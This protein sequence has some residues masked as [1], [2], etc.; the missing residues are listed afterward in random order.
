M[1]AIVSA[2]G[3]AQLSET[4]F[5]SITEQH[6]R[7]GVNKTAIEGMYKVY[8]LVPDKHIDNF[9]NNVLLLYSI[10]DAKS[11]TNLQNYVNSIVK[12]P[13][14][15][16]LYDSRYPH[17]IYPLLHTQVD[18]KIRY[19][20][21]PDEKPDMIGSETGLNIDT[22]T[23]GEYL[24]A[25]TPE[26]VVDSL[27]KGGN[28]RDIIDISPNATLRSVVDFK[29]NGIFTID[30]I[31]EE[32]REQFIS[33]A[34]KYING[35]TSDINYIMLFNQ[36]ALKKLEYIVHS[37]NY[38]G[39]DR[40]IY[41]NGVPVGN[42]TINKYGE[43]EMDD[44]VIIPFVN[45]ISVGSVSIKNNSN[46]I[47]RDLV[48]LGYVA[49]IIDNRLY[50]NTTKT[51]ITMSTTEKENAINEFKANIK[52]AAKEFFSNMKSS[53]RI[54]SPSLSMLLDSTSMNES[55]LINWIGKA[56]VDSDQYIS[57]ELKKL[58]DRLEHNLVDTDAFVSVHVI[59]DEL[60]PFIEN[61][62][63]S[64]RT[65]KISAEFSESLK[66]ISDSFND[67]RNQLH[68]FS[69]IYND[70]FNRFLTDR[71]G[72]D[73]D[74]FKYNNEEGDVD[75]Q[76]WMY[77]VRY[78]EKSSNYY[79]RKGVSLLKD[80]MSERAREITQ[81][82]KLDKLLAKMK[83]HG[84]SDFE[85]IY[86]KGRRN[87][88]DRMSATGFA[89]DKIHWGDFRG[90]LDRFSKFLAGEKNIDGSLKEWKA[91]GLYDRSVPSKYW[92]EYRKLVNDWLRLNTVLPMDESYLNAINELS[93]ETYIKYTD[94]RSHLTTLFSSL[95][96]EDIVEDSG[97][98]KQFIDAYKNYMFLFSEYTSSG[99]YKV[100]G[101]SEYKTYIELS[102]FRDTFN[103][104]SFDSSSTKFEDLKRA[105]AE[106]ENSRSMNKSQSGRLYGIFSGS[107]VDP[108]KKY[109]EDVNPFA[110]LIRSSNANGMDTS[111][112]NSAS[113]K[114]KS[115]M[116]DNYNMADFGRYELSS[117]YYN[118]RNYYMN[119]YPA[120]PSSD[121]T[122]D[123]RYLR[124]LEKINAIKVVGN[125]I[126]YNPLFWIPKR[127]NIDYNKPASVFA[128]DPETFS[129]KSG[130]VLYDNDSIYSMQ[131]NPNIYSNDRFDKL[132]DIQREIVD[133]VKE[134]LR[135]IN[136]NNGT[137]SMYGPLLP[138]RSSGMF[139]RTLRRFQS[140]FLKSSML[141]AVIWPIKTRFFYNNESLDSIIGFKKH[142]NVPSS[143]FAKNSQILEDPNTI[144]RDIL[145]LLSVSYND[146]IT[147]KVATKR[148]FA[149]KSVIDDAMG[150]SGKKNPNAAELLSKLANSFLGIEEF[151]SK[152]HEKGE[153]N[154]GQ[155][156]AD[157]LHLVRG[158]TL[159]WKW[160]PICA[161]AFG[162]AVNT[163]NDSTFIDRADLAESFKYTLKSVMSYSINKFTAIDKHNAN[164]DFIRWASDDPKMIKMMRLSGILVDND[165]KFNTYYG[166][167]MATFI[168]KHMLFGPYTLSDVLSIHPISHSVFK[169]IKY[170][171]GRFYG[172]YEF[173]DKFAK[174]DANDIITPKGRKDA[175]KKY[176]SI[177]ETLYDAYEYED[178][179]SGPEASFKSYGDVPSLKS[180]YAGSNANDM[181]EYA[182]TVIRSKHRS[183]AGN[184]SESFSPSIDNVIS[185]QLFLYRGW[186]INALNNLLPN[187]TGKGENK[188]RV[189]DP[190]AKQHVESQYKSAYRMFLNMLS[191]LPFISESFKYY[192]GQNKVP[193]S[194]RSLSQYQI[195]NGKLFLRNLLAAIISAAAGAILVTMS[196]DEINDVMYKDNSS[197]P[198]TPN[199]DASGV[200]NRKKIVNGFFVPYYDPKEVGLDAKLYK[201][202]GMLL[203]RLGNELS[204]QYN[205]TEVLNFPTSGSPITS[206]V[207]NASKYITRMAST[208]MNDPRIAEANEIMKSASGMSIEEMNEFGLYKSTLPGV[209][210]VSQINDIFN[211]PFGTNINVT[212]PFGIEKKMIKSLQ[213]YLAP[214]TYKYMSTIEEMSKKNQINTDYQ[215]DSEN[216]VERDDGQYGSDN[217][218]DG[219][220][221]NNQQ[222]IYG[223]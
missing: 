74:V 205:P 107:I 46:E 130:N 105:I 12:N 144:S 56:V 65:S 94:S 221:F 133:D 204:A 121:G 11:S 222:G 27:A 33:E 169:S 53:H 59:K 112:F 24:G 122:I 210:G 158:I 42:F 178:I 200:I 167:R 67:M 113:D 170:Y 161:N 82:D 90:E 8:D 192:E 73:P 9:I 189:Y 136:I 125:D 93:K 175:L 152:K 157:T 17:N 129:G 36:I 15:E 197:W 223:R 3:G 117:E 83:K 207:K 211:A 85:F 202:S 191:Y 194:S 151:G 115:F 199:V 162:A 159:S 114:M 172:K 176:K 124:E 217:Y 92:K 2:L 184:K 23:I 108:E 140:T 109:K 87:A 7:T 21:S 203:F 44:S 41:D 111:A 34:K 168:T 25:K 29:S 160:V 143:L 97:T 62:V 20:N 91:D 206:I 141:T 182:R 149:I 196:S 40:I 174:R 201:A 190:V 177:N 156:T 72:F 66:L 76:T 22:I 81:Y 13:N 78:P 88:L 38:I 4:E 32:S 208:D 103:P 195:D 89:I 61:L 148:L 55:E 102:K 35:G 19:F 119:R 147:N 58:Y 69:V 127:T 45:A 101:T 213:P 155:L 16:S 131:P 79:V 126:V 14:D 186:Q 142:N 26:E 212:L 6:H 164:S 116:L 134:I 188:L 49:N 52:T 48:N 5:V 218:N 96:A 31:P 64:L 63:N 132:S 57:S 193:I 187:M 71:Y 110:E 10:D 150:E 106:K 219:G 43:Y 139:S 163:M 84:I 51:I 70:A 39:K 118:L 146:S 104:E 171:N 179:S 137:I 50:V 47:V 54:I 37:T 216:D 28:K 198:K 120:K 100:N 30:L 145:K 185:P 173:I 68:D 153:F 180:E 209:M 80:M 98:Y 181:L 135:D 165:D 214:K 86:E 75:I 1:N 18:G 95:S 220:I 60:I 123:R 154:L 99:E 77:F 128:F 183:I 215:M 138:Q 166:K